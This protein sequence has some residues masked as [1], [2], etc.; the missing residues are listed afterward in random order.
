MPP[1][2]P[3]NGFFVANET[4]SSRRWLVWSLRIAALAIVCVGVH[5]T[6]RGALKQLSEYQWTVRPMWLILSGVIYAV[7][8]AP[9]GWFWWRTIRAFGYD[10]PLMPTYR[11]YYFGQMGKYVPGKAMVVVLRVAA[12]RRW[13]PSMRL[14]IVSV[15]VETL[16]VMAVGAMLAC[17]LSAFV[18]KSDAYIPLLALGMAGAAGG[19]T[20]PPF[21]RWFGRLGA[22]RFAKGADADSKAEDTAEVESRL[23]RI[24]LGVLSQ[25][26]IAASIAWVFYATSLWATLRGIGVANVQ[27]I[28]NMPVL[29]T[30]VAIAV[31]AG[32]LSMVPGGLVVRDAALARL[33]A[34]VCGD[35]NAVIAAVLMRLVWLVSEVVA[36]G[37][38]YIARPKSGQRPDADEQAAA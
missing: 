15:F 27:L 8:T 37:I 2:A 3:L 6:V 30:A 34:P 24:T 38:L 4:N 29:V 7:G 10:P 19:P 1:H 31:V 5:G 12:M 9:M 25:G 11:A 18:L 28:G 17:L 13:A 26:W 35:A 21:L 20:L 16:T 14:V 33:L 36:C 22:A 23:S 32:F